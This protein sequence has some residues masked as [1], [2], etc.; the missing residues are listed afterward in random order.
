MQKPSFLGR[1]EGLSCRRLALR[2]G[3]ESVVIKIEAG[4]EAQPGAPRAWDALSWLWRGD[5][6]LGV[7]DGAP[8]AC[9]ALPPLLSVLCPQPQESP[10]RNGRNVAA[11]GGKKPLRAGRGSQ[12]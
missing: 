12:Q 9:R 8:G 2:W 1:E 6:F 11:E 4:R 3:E 10:R 5:T 7:E